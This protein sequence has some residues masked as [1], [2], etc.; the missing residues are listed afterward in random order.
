MG[1]PQWV[2]LHLVP[3]TEGTNTMPPYVV[4]LLTS[5]APAH[6]VLN[7]MLEAQHDEKTNS[8]TFVPIGMNFINRVYVWRLQILEEKPDSDFLNA[9]NQEYEDTSGGLG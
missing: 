9:D 1:T 4:G 2:K 8:L 7:P 5:D 6:Y 3:Q